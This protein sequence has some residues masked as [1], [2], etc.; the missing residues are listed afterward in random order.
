MRLYRRRTAISTGTPVAACVLGSASDFV[1]QQGILCFL[2]DHTIKIM[3]IHG[4]GS[5]CSWPITTLWKD[6]PFTGDAD[7]ISLL[8]YSDDVLSLK[9]EDSV[10]H[11]DWL[12]VLKVSMERHLCEM[13]T[14][15]PL[16]STTKI[17]VRNT[18]EY[19]YYGTHSLTGNHGYHEWCIQGI[20]LKT[21]CPFPEKC[22]TTR[23]DGNK[24]QSLKLQLS[25][26]PGADI[27]S[28][29]TF[30]IHDGN[31]YAVSNCSSFGVVEV[32]WTSF[33]HCVRFPI[34]DPRPDTCEVNMRLYRRQHCE[35]PIHDS[36]TDLSLQVDEE[37]NRLMIVEARQEWLDGRSKQNRTFYMRDIKF[38]DINDPGEVM[39]LPADDA[40]V[41]HSTSQSKYARKQPRE[42]WQ[43]HHEEANQSKA[44]A[45]SFILAHTK[46]R[47]YNLSTNTF[48][49]LVEDVSCCPT[50]SK[51]GRRSSCLR[52][53]TGSRKLAPVLPSCE[54]FSGK[55]KAR[56]MSNAPSPTENHPHPLPT[57][58]Y[59]DGAPSPYQYS[60]ISMWPSPAHTSARA[61]R[62]HRILN[63]DAS[64]AV[65]DVDIKAVADERSIVFLTTDAAELATGRTGV[66]GKIVC[67]CFDSEVGVRRLDKLR[68]N[69]TTH[70]VK[71][72]EDSDDDEKQSLQS[73]RGWQ[74]TLSNQKVE[75]TSSCVS[76]TLFDG[77]TPGRD[78]TW[79]EDTASS[80]ELDLNDSGWGE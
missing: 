34:P 46:F 74:S 73:D 15:V 30:E 76:E 63:L 20:S 55:G 10:A 2:G 51:S 58:T 14:Y 66:K 71:K 39:E 70:H 52:L 68:F 26:F 54:A 65:P 53:R 18:R 62:A 69:S 61:T 5:E 45:P 79:S 78:E 37:T 77:H 21:D 19:L 72:E 41:P 49:D 56:A 32:D 44:Q 33:Y 75:M 12:L 24:F 40:F 7:S 22:R 16:D 43:V 25:N 38:L 28:T 48:L 9:F 17:F 8:Y 42:M 59:E 11:R 31:F 29:V 36:W 50:T 27:G 57:S 4:S 80:C 47:T 13:I 35:G 6:L 3:D 60:L 67:L 64:S 23:E 1:Y